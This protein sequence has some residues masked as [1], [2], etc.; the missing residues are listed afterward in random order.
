MHVC[1]REL[2]VAV[3]HQLHKHVFESSLCVPGPGLEAEDQVVKKTHQVP[4]L[5]LRLQGTRPRRT[6]ERLCLP[7]NANE[8]FRCFWG[9][10]PGT[11]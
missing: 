9:Q 6:E 2:N 1:G 7:C 4:V 11:S 5:R 10:N 8:G 3:I